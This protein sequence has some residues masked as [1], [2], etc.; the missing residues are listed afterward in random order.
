[1]QV[2][3]VGKSQNIFDVALA[4]YGSIEGLFDLMV[5]NPELSFDYELKE[6]EEL[7]YDEDCVV[8]DTVISTLADEGVSIANGERNVYHKTVDKDLRVIISVP[9]DDDSVT[10][11]LSGD[12]DMTVDWGDNSDI[13]T[14]ALQS[15]EQEYQHFYDNETDSRIVRL[16]GDFNVKTWYLSSIA[17]GLVLLVKPLTVDEVV[18]RQNNISLQGLLL[19]EGTYSVTLDGI[20]VSDL[21]MIRDMS[22]SD[23]TIS[24]LESS[25]KEKSLED[26]VDEYLIYVAKNHNERRDCKVV[27]DVQP[28]GEYAEP[29]KDDNGNYVIETGMEAVYVITHEDTWNEA[30]AWEFDICGETYKYENEGTA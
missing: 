11:K 29:S 15:T 25:D 8:Y 19:F 9:A 24:N 1:M 30:G 27:M 14:V 28:S 16:Y 20:A 22:L 23:L 10:L 7:Y 6:G 2:Y 3:K 18:V 12:G 5:N 13:E 4:C 17:S 21:D 26:I